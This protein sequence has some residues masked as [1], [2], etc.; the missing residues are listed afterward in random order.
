MNTTSHLVK[1]RTKPVVETYAVASRS[2]TNKAYH[3][4]PLHPH[5]KTSPLQ[6]YN[7]WVTLMA[8]APS[9]FRCSPSGT[10]TR[11]KVT[12]NPWRNPRLP[13][14]YSIQTN[15]RPR[16]LLQNPHPRHRFPSIS[17][18]SFL[19]RRERTCRATCL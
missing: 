1:D 2:S 18:G 4:R 17:S 14:S 3:S 5:R 9:I 7:H 15:H 12:S 19:H 6:I 8:T 11:R 10:R 16:Y 13:R